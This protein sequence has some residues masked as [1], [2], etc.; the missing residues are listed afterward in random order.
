MWKGER[1]NRTRHLVLVVSLGLLVG[2][3]IRMP[4]ALA[5]TAVMWAPSQTTADKQARLH[6]LLAEIAHYEHERQA[7]QAQLQS[8]QGEGLRAELT[9]QIRG[10]EDKLHALRG[11]F[12]QLVVDVDLQAF[13]PTE[14][15]RFDWAKE[16]QV[17]LSPLLNGV[18]RLTARP[19]A[20]DRLRE[21]IAR[22]REQ[23]RLTATA[24]DHIDQLAGQLPDPA[25]ASQFVQL[26]QAW[27]LRQLDLDTQL[28]TLQAELELKLGEAT[29]FFAM[30][31]DL[32]RSFFRSSGRNFILACLALLVVWFV[33]YRLHAWIRAVSPFHQKGPTAFV[34]VFNVIY[35][36]FT[37]LGA[38][39]IFLLVLYLFEDWVLLALSII[40]LLGIAWGAKSALPWIG[41]QLLVLLGLGALRDGER[42]LYNGVPWLVR[43]LTFYV[44]LVNPALVGGYVRLPLPSLAGLHS[45]PFEPSEPWF[46]TQ[47]D[48]W[49]LLGNQ[50]LGRVV[51]QT[52]EIVQ[53][54]VGGS[55]V[56]FRTPDFLAQHCRVL[57]RGFVRLLRF[58]I[59]Y[60]H[61]ARATRDIPAMLQSRLSQ[62]LAQE[63]YDSE[64]VTLAVEFEEAGASALQLVVLARCTGAVAPRYL[65]LG[66]AIQRLCVDACHEYGWGIPFPQL[67]LHLAESAGD[68][69]PAALA[70]VRKDRAGAP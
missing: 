55:P 11:E 52:P 44:H 68:G 27:E 34:R 47:V 25:L 62:G 67:T 63:G 53:I 35:L 43:S 14:D 31:K 13:S 66:R 17:L 1:M 70:D 19:R 51:L 64:A 18:K 50:T 60:R 54:A 21:Q 58:G 48:D 6:A 24:L 37:V 33:L 69:S 49:V 46:P 5:Q 28:A 23:R 10:I 59:D 4:T 20:I 38:L 29:P 22:A 9:Q 57:S 42:V 40:V 26:R 56:S 2:W 12:E 32:F 39:L 15:G 7:V 61:Q 30:L 41:Y 65:A 3:L 8:P 45:R 16:V 36:V